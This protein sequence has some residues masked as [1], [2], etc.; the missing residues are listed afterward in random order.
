MQLFRGVLI[1]ILILSVH[2]VAY[3]DNSGQNISFGQRISNFLFGTGDEALEEVQKE[4]SDYVEAFEGEPLYYRE[5]QRSFETQFLV[6]E[7]F[8]IQVQLDVLIPEISMSREEY[9]AYIYAEGLIGTGGVIRYDLDAGTSN[10]HGYALATVGVPGFN[11]RMWVQGATT[12]ETPNA[13]Y[14]F[15]NLLEYMFADPTDI[16]MRDVELANDDFQVFFSQPDIDPSQ[17]IVVFWDENDEVS[18]TGLPYEDN[19]I[20]MIRS[21]D[22]QYPVIDTTFQFIANIYTASKISIYKKL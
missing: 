18:H 14:E 17:Y 6:Y 7:N 9:E 4:P 1:C 10:C 16:D 19:D 21:K 15:K 3:S 5:V 12:S 8:N 22:R 2:S 13:G 11:K 20:F